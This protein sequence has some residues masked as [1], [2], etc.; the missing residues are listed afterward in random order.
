MNT[1]LR[2]LSAVVMAMFLV[3]MV[4]T[5]YIQYVRAG[6]LNE[7]SRNARKIYRDLGAARGPIVV[8]D[9]NIVISKE[10]DDDYGRQRIYAGGKGEVASMY[11][12]ITGYFA[13]TGSVSGLENAN[14]DYLSGRADSLWLDQLQNLI[15]GQTAEGSSVVTTIDPAV[16]QAAWD[17]L[18][19]YTGAAV[20]LDPK[21]GAILAMVSKPS[22]D[23]NTMAVHDGQEA[24][25]AINIAAATTPV[26]GSLAGEE[27]RSSYSVLHNRTINALYPPGSTFKVFTSAAAIESGKFRADTK[28]PAPNGYTLTGTQTKV[29]NFGGYECVAGQSEITLTEALKVSCNSAYLWLGGKVG[30]EAMGDMFEDFHFDEALEVPLDTTAGTYPGVDNNEGTTTAPIELTGM[31]QGGV[32]KLSPLQVAMMTATV[33]NGGTEMQPYLV[34]EIRDSSL[35]TVEKTQPDVLG[36]PI[37]S[38]TAE[39]LRA[40]MT[41]V[42]NGEGGSGV[43]A[44]IPGVTVAGKTGTAED[45]PRQPTLWFTGFAPAE[46]PQVAVAVVLE[47]AGASTEETASSALAA[48]VAKAVLEAAL[49]SGSDR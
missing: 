4:S 35:N 8:G 42:V 2:R 31:G 7:D 36:N 34:D 39:D 46:D 5:T 3:L 18:G 17:A 11:A 16:Q 25:A 37:S 10:V 47:N 49:Q 38:S 20:A 48:P 32:L 24:S 22:Y 40:M 43:N 26:V 44:Q 13:V 1:T 27:R 12:P 9:E 14:N 21:T 45:P 28:V 19:D 15:T 41:E 29:N 23:P 33:A 6:E 30:A